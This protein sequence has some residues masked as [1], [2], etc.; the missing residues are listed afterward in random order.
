Q[1]LKEPGSFKTLQAPEASQPGVSISCVPERPFIYEPAEIVVK[2]EGA[3]SGA[4]I[5]L[6]EDAIAAP[7]KLAKPNGPLSAGQANISWTPRE[8]RAY[9]L[10]VVVTSAEKV[11]A[12]AVYN[13]ESARRLVVIDEAH[14][15]SGKGYFEDMKV[16]LYNRGLTAVS[17]TSKISSAMLANARVLVIS[18]YPL[19]SPGIETAEIAAIRDFVN[20]GGGLLLIGTCD[21]KGASNPAALNRILEQVGSNMRVNDDEI[22]DP[23]NNSGGQKWVVFS[24]IF[25]RRVVPAE[26]MASLLASG[27]SIV[28]SAMK[29]VTAADKTIIPLASGDDDTYNVDADGAG[30]AVI[31]PAG[32]PIVMDAAEIMPSGGKIALFGSQHFGSAVYQFTGQHQTP[33]YNYNVISWLSRQAK[34]GVEELSNEITSMSSGAA[35]EKHSAV[36]SKTA[37]IGATIRADEFFSN[38]EKEFDPSSTKL[39]AELDSLIK[40]VKADKTPAAETA[41]V[42]KKVLDRVR[43][44]AV[45]DTQLMNRIKLKIAILEDHYQKLIK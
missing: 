17:N 24:H 32:T 11:I 41:A 8:S 20:S 31:Y 13:V 12:V 33:L 42:I 19:S 1:L 38:I 22:L 34:N 2:L 18:Q 6:Y 44:G 3:P 40:H 28:N 16:D 10:F 9:E 35:S 5:T 14:D 27:A 4:G 43:Y 15:N 37:V 21:F 7:N 23:T 45:Q 39:E 36:T 29:P 26:I 25:D 30:D